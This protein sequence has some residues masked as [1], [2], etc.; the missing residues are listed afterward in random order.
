MESNAS[1]QDDQ[2]IEQDAPQTPADEQGAER[3]FSQA[4]VDR[5][6]AD[7]LKRAEDATTRR[8]LE[9]LGVESTDALRATMQAAR[10]REEAEMSE[11]DKLRK[12]L[13]TLE[14]EKTAAEQR[15][16]EI[17]QQRKS[18]MRRHAVRAALSDAQHPDDV[19]LWIDANLREA[20]EAVM[21]DEGAINDKAVAALVT[22]VKKQRPTFFRQPGP[23]SPSVRGG[24]EA[25]PDIDAILKQSPKIRL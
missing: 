3:T 23:G 8:L 20:Y 2:P 9:E 17:E 13:E 7:R 15:A 25:K 16:Q 24:K 18:D 19:L 1:P 21:S 11:L 5:I 22:E 14:A 12:Q 10:E 6:I 4:D